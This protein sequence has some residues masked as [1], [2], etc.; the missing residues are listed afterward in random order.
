MSAL[1][2]MRETYARCWALIVNNQND[3]HRQQQQQKQ[4]QNI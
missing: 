3:Q 2:R 4:D 1:A